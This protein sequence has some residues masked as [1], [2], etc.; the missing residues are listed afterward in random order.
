VSDPAG[1]GCRA[2]LFDLDGTLADTAPDMA[3]ALN[4]LRGEQ[5]LGPLPYPVIRPRVSHG[6]V[7]LV[8]L[9]FGLEPD[10]PR[11]EPLL[12]RFRDLYRADLASRTRLFDGMEGLLGELEGRGLPWGIVTNKPAWL[13]GPLLEAMGLDRRAGCIVSGDT[14]AHAK[15]HPAPMQHATGTLGVDPRH[16]IYVGDAERDIQAGRSVGMV[17]LIAG[18][19]YLGDDDI[20]GEWGADGRIEHPA[21]ILDWVEQFTPRH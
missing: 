5:G 12:L 8:R 15:P 19:G 3:D 21:E 16:C 7:A 9:G 11:F 17:T 6:G 2:V 14:T 4:R 1:N 13:T 20:P 18:F 10:D